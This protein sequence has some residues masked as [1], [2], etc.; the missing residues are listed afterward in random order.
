MRV[1][2]D[3]ITK[4]NIKPEA[5]VILTDG[6]TSWP[7]SIPCPTLWAITEDHIDAPIGTTIRLKL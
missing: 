7:N 3:H 2:F 6:L 4:N 5:I 1:I